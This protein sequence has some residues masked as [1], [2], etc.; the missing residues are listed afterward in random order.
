LQAR[1]DNAERFFDSAA[2]AFRGTKREDKADRRCAQ[3]DADD[4]FS[5]RGCEW[6]DSWA[7]V[8]GHEENSVAV[9]EPAKAGHCEDIVERLRADGLEKNA[10]SGRGARR[11]GKASGPPP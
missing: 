5:F 6:R 9:G 8:L 3:N 1:G 2:A 4:Q 11:G 10:L 7:Q